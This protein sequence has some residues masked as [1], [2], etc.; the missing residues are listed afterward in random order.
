MVA[1][2]IEDGLEEVRLHILPCERVPDQPQQQV[3]CATSENTQRAGEIHPLITRIPEPLI[4]GEVVGLKVIG[5]NNIGHYCKGLIP[6]TGE[7]IHRKRRVPICR[8]NNIVN[9]HTNYENCNPCN[10]SEG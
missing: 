10:S 5:E 1:G 2:L 3:R 4:D 7:G 9:G 8:I 6:I